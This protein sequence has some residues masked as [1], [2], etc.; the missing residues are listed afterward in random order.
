MTSGSRT[1][2]TLFLVGLWAVCLGLI[3]PIA[4]AAAADDFSAYPE[5]SI[6]TRYP[7]VGDE[8]SAVVDK[9]SV[10]VPDAYSYQWYTYDRF[11]QTIPIPGATGPTFTVTDDEVGLQLQVWVTASKAGFNDMTEK[12][13]PTGVVKRSFTSAPVVS[14]DDTTPTIGQPVSAVLEKPAVPA[15]ESYFYQW[16]DDDGSPIYKANSATYT[17]QYYAGHSLR[18]TV[19]AQKF[20]YYDK[21]GASAWT[22]EIAKG[23]FTADPTPTITDP[24]PTTGQALSASITPSSPA[25][26]SYVRQWNADG[27]AIAGAT[28]YTFTPTQAE[29][30]K[31]I[32][33]SITA[34]K[35]GYNDGPEVTSAPTEAVSAAPVVP[36]AF[37]TG[38]TAN[39]STT[40]PKVGTVLKVTPTGAS[41]A[42][43]SYSYE[44]QK[45]S[46]LGVRTTIAGALGNEYT[47]PFG[48]LTYRL[49]VRVTSIKSGYYP[50]AGPSVW[51]AAV[52]HIVLNKTTVL[53]AQTHGV[54]DKRMRG[55]QV[56]RIFIDGK[57]V[58]QGVTSSNGTATRTVGVPRTI[59]V[60]TR[61][62]WVSGYNK[63][64]TR[65]FQVITTVIVK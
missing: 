42:P 55:E 46:P 43:D 37:S 25:A 45:T 36:V 58:Y 38:P 34:I 14:I 23:D 33:V 20:N 53:S 1:R 31:L 28:G 41:P 39:L 48:D 32:T 47:V 4:P 52:N 15:P 35:Y 63:A 56:Y 60:G 29:V 30:G 44:W 11:W 50:I 65:D 17:P 59:P 8:V 7:T 51:T 57:R 26:D 54:N 22:A 5:I 6:D 62:V 61:R 2:R 13:Y 18:V 9:D 10:P 21:V 27:V 12:S 49:R 24:T 3:A 16:F 19:T 64:G 40:A